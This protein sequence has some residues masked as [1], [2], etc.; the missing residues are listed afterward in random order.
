VKHLSLAIEFYRV[1]EMV[2]F[3]DLDVV[4]L[5]EAPERNDP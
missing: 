4:V 5:E 1:A 2:L 3:Q